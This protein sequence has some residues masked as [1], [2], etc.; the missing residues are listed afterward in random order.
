MYNVVIYEQKAKNIIFFKIT[1]T[2]GD[3]YLLS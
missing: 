2:I 1:H 3:L